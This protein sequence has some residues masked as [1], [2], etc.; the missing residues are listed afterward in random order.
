MGEQKKNRKKILWRVIISL[1]CLLLGFGLLWCARNVLGFADGYLKYIYPIWVNTLGRLWGI[2]PFS[3]VEILLYGLILFI[4]GKGIFN[5]VSIIL[6]KKCIGQT[7]M[8]GGTFVLGVASILFLVYVLNCGINYSA[9]T[10]GETYGLE[11]RGYT[12]E[13]L[14]E[15]C[16]LLTEYVLGFSGDVSRD[17]NYLM[18]TQKSW[19][20][21]AVTSMERVGQVYPLLNVKYP[22]PKGIAVSQILSWQHITGVY[23]PFTVEANYNEDMVSYN[24]PFTMCHELSHLSGFMQEDEANFIAWLAC[25]QSEDGDFNYSGALMGWIYCTNEL[26][27]VDK[28]YYHMLYDALPEVV[29]TEL[30]ANNRFWDDYEGKVTETAQKVNDSYLKAHKQEEGIMT[31]DRVV[32]L[33]VNYYTDK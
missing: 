3:V 15:V 11:R 17:E 2:V 1:I 28:E 31:Y 12:K 29:K 21:E 33:I 13:E 25:M 20:E 16:H 14:T 7:L 19:K 9:T 18:I 26:Y 5:I 32:D 8:R 27:N 23:S 22:V 10:F 6:K 24:I 4:L 30:A